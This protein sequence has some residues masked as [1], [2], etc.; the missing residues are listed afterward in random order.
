M[1]KI[2]KQRLAKLAHALLSHARGGQIQVEGREPINFNMSWYA[3]SETDSDVRPK[4]VHT[5]GTSC[6]FIGY[7]P[8]IFPS[9]RRCHGWGGVSRGVIGEDA[10]DTWDFLFNSGWRDDPKQAARRALF[11]LRDKKLPDLENIGSYRVEYLKSLSN[12]AVL[13]ELETYF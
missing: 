1:K 9:L 8:V 5:C 11:V 4:T 3:E 6:C 7:A 13:A 2:H 10:G 12:K